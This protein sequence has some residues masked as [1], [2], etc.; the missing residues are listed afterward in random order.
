MKLLLPLAYIGGALAALA[1]L[2]VTSPA[3]WLAVIALHFVTK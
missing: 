3:F 1:V 2:C